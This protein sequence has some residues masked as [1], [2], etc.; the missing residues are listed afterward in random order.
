MNKKFLFVLALPCFLCS[1]GENESVSN[2]SSIKTDEVSISFAKTR[3][4]ISPKDKVTIKEDAAGVK[5]SFQGGTPE[6]VTLN[7]E[8]GEIDFDENGS[9]I[10]EKVYIA[11]LGNSQA[12]TI[13][14]FKIKEDKPV[15]NFEFDSDYAVNGD[16]IKAKAT[17]STS[18]KEYAV[19]YSLSS[20]IN[21]IS[22]D[23]NTGKISI[24][25]EVEDKT[26]FEVVA[27]SKQE[28]KSKKLFALT[29]NIIKPKRKEAIMEKSNLEDACFELDFNGNDIVSTTTKEN[30]SLRIDGTKIEDFEYDS[31]NH[32][33][34]VSS[35]KFA[36][37]EVGSFNVNVSTLRNRVNF[38]LV[39]ASK[40]IYEASEFETIFEPNYDNGTPSFKEGSLQ[41]YYV[42]GADIDLSSSLKE[43]GALYHNGSLFLPL[44]AYE[45]GV[46]SVPFEGTFDGNGHTISSFSYKGDKTPVNGLFGYNKG[47][48]KNLTLKG[49][50]DN[51]KSWSGALV[52]NN[53]GT[54][55]G[56]ICDV[57]L[58]NQGQ[59]ATGVIASVNHGLIKDCFSIN[60]NVT[61]YNQA[62]KNYQNSGIIVG[63][64]DVDGLIENVYGVSSE[65]SSN[66]IGFS[67]NSEVSETSAG[68]KFASK[69][70]LLSADYSSFSSEY[71]TIK[72]GELSNN[73]LF[74]SSN[75]G[76]FD[77]DPALPSYLLKGKE[78]QLDM[79]I[80]PIENKVEAM[81]LV[82]F[83]IVGESH[84]IAIN[85]N[86][87]DASLL[88]VDETNITIK[89]SLTFNGKNYEAS[90]DIKV[91]KSLSEVSILNDE[92][93]F[94]SGTRIK[95][96]AGNLN[97]IDVETTFSLDV[98]EMKW[99]TRFFNIS[100]D[101]LYIQDDVPNYV[102][103]V[104]IK[105][106][107]LGTT[108]KTKTFQ[109]KQLKGLDNA[110]Q[111]HYKGDE[112][113]FVYDINATEIKEI[114]LMGEA[115][116][117]TSYSFSS[118]KLSIDPSALGTFD[119][120]KELV[121][122]ADNDA[123]RIFANRTNEEKLTL[124][125]LKSTYGE[126][127]VITISSLEEF[128][129]YF[130]LDGTTNPSLA[131]SF[132]KDK[133]YALTSDLDFASI[134]NFK[135]IGTD[136][137]GIEEGQDAAFAGKLFGLGHSISSINFVNEGSF[138][139]AGL[140]NTLEGSI[141]DLNLYNVNIS[142]G[143]GNFVGTV[144]GIMGAEAKISNVNAFNCNVVINSGD[145]YSV[146][147]HGEIALGGLVGKTWS[148]SI[149]LSTYN[150]YSINL[151]GIKA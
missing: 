109:I 125:S 31:L 134:A 118:N 10:P 92:E 59:S 82:S 140:F 84:G 75:L 74:V 133:V 148:S 80:L 45:D 139:C 94:V 51:P 119:S 66:L 86:K 110:N 112:S 15:I 49:N 116:P 102:S 63:L 81:K 54:I 56:V 93:Y 69:E 85:G 143:G 36:S 13:V 120:R 72:G 141:I 47:T 79:V 115:L 17:S 105:A 95:L 53:S 29:K 8:T 14:S 65:S 11:T 132:S 103:S 30:L 27:T 16:V 108:S 121:V 6:G 2:E 123:Y 34:K 71:I 39:I 23:S 89:A 25:N 55:E 24:S 52:G 3:Y 62:D 150:G 1:C 61:G 67:L 33:V 117:K 99:K 111:I 138:Y 144:A 106:T 48:I 130:A 7:E 97:N 26:E 127:K 20:S 135:P 43:G 98:D 38:N 137:Y 12:S 88:N 58:L 50:I 76:K 21:G 9:S 35:S 90:K 40:I 147:N 113:N 60:E 22:I 124:E 37:L 101:Y 70:E 42:L 136:L 142:L 46:Y 64:N 128:K 145:G 68:K 122:Y 44:G 126:D 18:S 114:T 104:S 73:V 32:I 57:S 83:E 28:K 149:N 151:Y 96:K 131:S 91:Y 87:I 77:F 129:Q 4:E 41:G 5:Y 107:Q 78:Y 146:P 19:T 100:G